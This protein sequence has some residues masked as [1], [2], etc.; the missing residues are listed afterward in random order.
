MQTTLKTFIQIEPSILLCVAFLVMCLQPL[1]IVNNIGII[2]YNIMWSAI[3]T[4]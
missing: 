1:F 2:Y 3:G 4:K